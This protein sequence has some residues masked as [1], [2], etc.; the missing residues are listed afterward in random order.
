MTSK[1][2]PPVCRLIIIL[3]KNKTVGCQGLQ[4][5]MELEKPKQCVYS[6][7]GGIYGKKEAAHIQSNS[8]QNNSEQNFIT[9]VTWKNTSL[10]FR[11][12]HIYRSFI[13]QM[14]YRARGGSGW[15]WCILKLG[16]QRHDTGR[17]IKWCT[18]HCTTHRSSARN[19]ESSAVRGLV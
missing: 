16:Y 4:C 12:M 9:I 7:A 8:L 10:I 11:P 18:F 2:W 5:M 17:N 14:S 3:I 6:I 15:K 13:G 1:I 19:H